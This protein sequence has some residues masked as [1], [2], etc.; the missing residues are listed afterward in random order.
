MKSKKRSVTDRQYHLRRVR[1]GIVPVRKHLMHYWGA[2]RT[3]APHS[4]LAMHMK[5]AGKPFAVIAHTKHDTVYGIPAGGRMFTSGA[6]S[7]LVDFPERKDAIKKTKLV[8]D[9]LEVSKIY[10]NMKDTDGDG[11]K[12]VIDCA[13]TNPRKQDIKTHTYTH[14]SS[15]KADLSGFDFTFEPIEDSVNV[16]ETPTGYEVKY[17]TPDPDPESPSEWED[18]NA[19]LVNYH[20]DFEVERDSV[21]RKEDL[22]DLYIGEKTEKT[23]ELQKKY[24]IFPV[25][26][27]IHGGVSLR[28]EGGFHGMLPQG[29]EEFDV[30][31][32][33]A[34]FLAKSEWKSEK[35][36]EEYAK[37]QIGTWNEYLSGDVYSLVNEKYDKGKKQVDY[38]VVGGYSGYKYALE[39]LKTE[40]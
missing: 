1:S 33:G 9:I 17:M 21:L 14:Y 28:L 40:I 15:D 27:Y 8:K 34:V 16:K 36:A 19:F 24:W 29:H 11:V 25:D 31:H 38:D 2:V 26:A 7:E 5:I 37:A 10:D 6:L 23:K 32:V 30:S 3:T 22:R 13:P 4:E 39:S 12:D 18:D 35:K 20:T